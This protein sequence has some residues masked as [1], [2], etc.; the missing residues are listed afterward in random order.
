MVLVIVGLAATGVLVYVY[1]VKN[2]K[3]KYFIT[4][5]YDTRNKSDVAGQELTISQS[6]KESKPD[7]LKVSNVVHNEHAFD[8]EKDGNSEPK[9]IESHFD[10]KT[11]NKESSSDSSDDEK[12]KAGSE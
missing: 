11:V 1:A 4:D 8:H 3:G 10:D 9:E 2:R 5:Q 6:M 7:N 12:K